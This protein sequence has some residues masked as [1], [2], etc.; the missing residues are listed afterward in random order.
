MTDY[1]KEDWVGL[2]KTALLE[3]E[4]A[5]MH[6][7]IADARESIV[8]RVAKLHSLPGLHKEER[9]AIQDALNN[10]RVLE[11]EDQQYTAE[12]KRHALEKAHRTLQ[13]LAPKILRTE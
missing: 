12:E 5:K 13:A 4:H 8:T 6:G 11:R 1:D 2:Y 9:Q 3:L 10:L 7:R